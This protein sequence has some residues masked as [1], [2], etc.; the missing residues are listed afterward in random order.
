M[1][2]KVGIISAM[3]IHSLVT[4]TDKSPICERCNNKLKESYF[5]WLREGYKYIWKC[6]NPEC[7]NQDA[8]EEIRIDKEKKDEDARQAL[9]TMKDDFLKQPTKI[10]GE[11]GVPIKYHNVS[12]D[13]FK[14]G[15]KYV[16]A[17]RNYLSEPNGS[18]Y[19]YGNCGSGK[20]H[21]AVSILRE[22]YLANV[23]LKAGFIPTPNLLLQI[24]DCFNKDP[25][26]TEYE[27]VEKYLNY[28]VLVL[29]DMGAEKTTEFSITT[30]Y[31]IINGRL[32]DEKP[33]I[34][35][36]NLSRKQFETQIDNRI[37]SRFAEYKAIH[38][39]MPDHRKNSY[40]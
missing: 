2:P 25:K 32:S 4:I 40:A 28:H 5:P 14:G 1:Q 10:M 30:L 18:L 3:G 12:L 17:I 33:T 20:T 37:A 24:R 23:T 13:S 7:K 35:T 38:L 27:I 39:D 19:I 29:D 31:L 8:E 11:M 36:S 6:E 15:E 26:F 16:Q 22:L 34:V 9:I 21:L